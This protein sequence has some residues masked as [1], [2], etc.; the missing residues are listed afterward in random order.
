MKLKIDLVAQALY[1]SEHGERSPIP[2]NVVAP[3]WSYDGLVPS[4]VM[5]PGLAFT[6]FIVPKTFSSGQTQGCRGEWLM[7]SLLTITIKQLQNQ[8]F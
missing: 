3:K 8:R 7:K 4:L 6:S 2:L 1:P 5:L